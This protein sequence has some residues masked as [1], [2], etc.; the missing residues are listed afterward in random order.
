MTNIQVTSQDQIREIIFSLIEKITTYYCISEKV[1]EI[2][3]FLR[4]KLEN[5]GYKSEKL[6]DFAHHLTIDLQQSANDFHFW[7]SAK[8]SKEKDLQIPEK[9]IQSKNEEEE[10]LRF[11]NCDIVEAERLPGNIGYLK[12]YE[13]SPIHMAAPIILNALD[14]LKYTDALIIDVRFNGG[15]DSRLVQYIISYFTDYESIHLYD[16]ENPRK[17]TIEQTWTIPFIGRQHHPNKLLYIL[18]S[19]RSASAAEDLA[20]TLQS[21][22]RATI[23]GETTR[24]AANAPEIY[25]VAGILDVEI[26]TYRPVNVQ[27]Q[28][29]WEQTGVIPDIQQNQENALET[30]HLH[31]ISSLEKLK[32]NPSVQAMFEFEKEYANTLYNSI[33]TPRQIAMKFIGKYGSISLEF[34]ENTLYLCK[35][36]VQYPLITTDNKIFFLSE[37]SRVRFETEKE[38]IEMIYEFREPWDSLKYQKESLNNE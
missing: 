25:D 35:K 2:T 11:T 27:T 23:I 6:S 31:A 14:Y 16:F 32:R 19:H 28:S 38:S 30:A 34:R 15:G 29:N 24:G 21:I 8:T 20:Y 5:G 37:R 17:K 22:K 3:D 12:L 33:S 18:T 26:P 7:I 4:K 10:L 9:S 13:F 1:P 36:K